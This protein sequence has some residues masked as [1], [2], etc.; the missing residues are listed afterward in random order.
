MDSIRRIAAINDLSGGCRCS[1]T[2]ALPIISA[3]G[4]QCCVLPTAILSN[5][6]GFKSFFFD[7]YTDKMNKFSCEWQKMNLK[8]DCIYSG[9]LGSHKQIEE[10]LNFIDKFKTVSTKIVIDPVMGDNGEIYSTYSKEMCDD[11]KLLV[12]KAD[13]V[14][15]NI[16][17]ACSLSDT[18]YSGE[19][20]PEEALFEMAE[21]IS[22]LGAK[23][24]IIT[25]HRSKTMVANFVYSAGE[26]KSFKTP[27]VPKYF[28]GTGDVFASVI[29]S[30]TCLG[31][32]VF[33]A[34]E[35]AAKFVHKAASMS[36][37]LGLDVND[38][39]CFEKILGDLT[40]LKGKI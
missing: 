16:T 22:R 13:I 23:N 15:P 9:F 12:S 25:G 20:L 33:K 35:F 3:L 8:F 17:E 24:V 32:D 38:G 34:T 37:C 19:T 40:D 7:D 31:Y 2:A 21:K 11:M 26:C 5:H 27:V 1:L 36:Y 4:I 39:I 6:T 29:A 10:V 30:L 28:S 14:T 18:K